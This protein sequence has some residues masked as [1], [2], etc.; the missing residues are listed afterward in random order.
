MRFVSYKDRKIVVA[1]FK[2]IYQALTEEA[3]LGALKT[4]ETK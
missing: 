2:E 4:F 3:T 1:D